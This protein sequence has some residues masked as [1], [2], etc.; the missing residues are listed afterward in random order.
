MLSPYGRCAESISS[1]YKKAA[2]KLPC[3]FSDNA[4]YELSVT[5]VV[6]AAALLLILGVS[7]EST[8]TTTGSCTDRRAF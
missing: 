4:Y 6:A 5:V 8:C 1:K 7:V 2:R 3:G